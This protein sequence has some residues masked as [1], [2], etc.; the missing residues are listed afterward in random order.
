[1]WNP[2]AKSTNS[3]VK[4]YFLDPGTKSTNSYVKGFYLCGTPILN[5]NYNMLL[6]SYYR[7]KN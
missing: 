1:M 6:F 5:L 4:K 3:Y 7:V 2:G